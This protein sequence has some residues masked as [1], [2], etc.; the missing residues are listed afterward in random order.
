MIARF[1][2]RLTFL[3]YRFYWENFI[4]LGAFFSYQSSFFLRWKLRFGRE[5]I[6]ACAFGGEVELLGKDSHP[7]TIIVRAGDRI[8]NLELFECDPD[9][10][11]DCYN[12]SHYTRADYPAV[13]ILGNGIHMIV[14]GETAGRKSYFVRGYQGDKVRDTTLVFSK[15][16]QHPTVRREGALSVDGAYPPTFTWPEPR[17]SDYWISFLMIFSPAT[18][19]LKIGVYSWANRWRFP[20]VNRA[21]YYY[22]DALPVPT[23][24]PGEPYQAVYL[25]IDR[26]GWIPFLDMVPVERPAN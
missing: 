18:M 1:T 9:L 14:T 2:S 17:D 7:V 23:L 12:K 19:R 10:G 3:V 22:H 20:F 15:I 11:H 4:R 25:A 21:P 26:E 13:P 24:E 16:D 8:G 5:N 6:L